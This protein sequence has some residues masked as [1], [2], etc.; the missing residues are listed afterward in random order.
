MLILQE[1]L[2]HVYIG[3]NKAAMMRTQGMKVITSFVPVT[4]AQPRMEK[5]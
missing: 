3:N 2:V 1:M 5:C 4:F